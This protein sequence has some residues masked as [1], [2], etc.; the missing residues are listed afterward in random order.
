M[1][2]PEVRAHL[3]EY[4][5]VPAIRVSSQADVLFAAESLMAGGLPIMEV[6]MTVP[7][8]IQVVSDLVKAHPGLVVG[9]GSILDSGT[10]LRCIDA[11]ALFL[12]STGFEAGVV[13]LAIKQG[14]LVFPGALT[15]HRSYHCLE[16]GLRFRQSVPLRA[17]GR[18]QLYPC[19]ETPLPHVSLIQPEA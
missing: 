8:A 15:A 11:G 1:T 18:T 6:T 4:G 5:I 19:L 16:G 13:E 7:G 10:A 9:A 14:I 2:K 17:G 12:T 3:E